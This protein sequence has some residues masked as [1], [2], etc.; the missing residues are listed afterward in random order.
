MD[1]QVQQPRATNKM[2]YYWYQFSCFIPIA[3]YRLLHFHIIVLCS[4]L[5]NKHKGQRS[6]SR[7]RQPVAIVKPI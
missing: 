6:L 1:M 7:N 2:L 3:G 4:D 5:Q